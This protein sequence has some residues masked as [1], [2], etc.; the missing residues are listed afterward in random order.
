VKISLAS[1][2]EV[3]K[4]LLKGK[5][6][7]S[8]ACRKLNRVRQTIYRY[9]NEVARGG[10]A[11]LTDNRH[12]NNRKLSSRQRVEI[13]EKKKEKPFRSARKVLELTRSNV[14]ERWVQKIWEKEGLSRIN[15]ERL[16]P[17]QRFVAQ[18]PNDLWQTDIMGRIHFPHLGEAYLIANIDDCSR[19]ILGAKWFSQQTQINVFRVWY[20]CLFQWGLPETMLSDKGSQYRSTN[21]KGRA[22]YQDYAEALGI[23]LIFAHQAQTKGKIERL[24]RFIQQ[25]FVRENLDVRS[26]EELN[27]R[28]FAWQIRFNEEFKSK[29]LGM[30]GKTPAEVYLPS[31]RRRPESELSELLTIV[32]RRYV[33]TDSTISL[34]GKR[35]KV[36]PGYIKCRIWLKIRGEN[37]FLE[38]MDKVILKFKLKV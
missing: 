11:A 36:P 23:K 15:I 26:F 16:K 21:P 7:T 18:N 2:Q 9:L 27:R 38:A 25:D 17:I 32:K 37:V 22:A 28:F 1:K 10:L 30:D 19:F 12:S 8:E 34:F 20:H 6:T 35:Y 3:I 4:E 29:G 13:L 33:Y 24:W 31:E 5:I 14:T